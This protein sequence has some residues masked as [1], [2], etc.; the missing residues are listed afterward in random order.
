MA[1]DPVDLDLGAPEDS[2]K[3]H[4]GDEDLVVA[5]NNARRL[6]RLVN[7]LL[8]FQKLEAGKKELSL[9][10]LNLNRFTHV[11]GDYFAS[12]CSSKDID[13]H[14][15]RDGKQLVR[16]ARLMIESESD[17]LEKVAF[18]FLSNALKYTP[19]GGRIEL[20]L[21]LKT[22]SGF[23]SLSKILARGFLKKARPSSFRFLV[24]STNPPPENTREPV[25]V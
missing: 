14:V 1:P 18:N 11:L 2:S 13:F 19:R 12:A 4:A 15:T 9:S 7:Q 10:P 17:A 21:R 3:R 25:L 22:T 8:D 6:L 16:D 24:R 23:A 5:T 20:D